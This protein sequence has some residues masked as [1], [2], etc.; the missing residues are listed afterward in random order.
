MAA[1]H[2][3]HPNGVNGVNGAAPSFL[4]PRFS[5]V[6]SMLLVPIP[7]P[8]SGAMMDIESSLEDDIADDPTEICTLLENEKQDKKTWMD[9]ATAYAKHNKVDLAIE[10]L[11]QAN[12]AFARGRSDDRLSILNGLCWLYLL[13]MRSAPRVKPGKENRSAVGRQS[14]TAA[15]NG[16][17]VKTKDHYV[18]Q[19]TSII[20]EAS[21][22]NPSY[23]PLFLTRGVLLLLRASLQAPSTSVGPN[24]ANTERIDLLKQAAKSFEDALRYS[25]Q[26]NLMARLGKARALYSMRQYVDACRIYQSVMEDSPGLIDPDPRIGIGCC[27]WQLGHKKEATKAWHRSRQLV[28]FSRLTEYTPC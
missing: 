12:Q 18:Q 2:S 27:Y 8:D 20:N 15:D 11:S 4:P 24:H 21:R 9:V 23:A 5:A 1:V 25:S 26:R 17:D 19:V 10:V 3:S 7:D 28:R 6:P 16:E 14:L 13:K 22:I